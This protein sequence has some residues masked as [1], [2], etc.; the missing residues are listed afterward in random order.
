MTL[1]L[2]DL[3]EAVRS[4]LAAPAWL[5][6][7]MIPETGLSLLVGAPKSGKSL[8]AMALALAIGNGEPHHYL[9]RRITRRPVLLV[10][11]EGSEASLVDRTRRLAIERGLPFGPGEIFVAHRPRGFTLPHHLEA[12]RS[13]AD[14]VNAG[15]VIID[16]LAAVLGGVDENSAAG[17]APVLSALVDLGRDRAV[18]VIHH[19][20]K[21]SAEKNAAGRDPFVS[22][23]GS[24]AIFAAA[25]SAAVLETTDDGLHARL[26]IRPRDA[27]RSILDL[28]R[29]DDGL[30]W[31]SATAPGVA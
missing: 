11:M 28:E 13:A 23:R 9:G 3:A 7:E 1:A 22:I 10:E 12:L 15:L 14:E 29:R 16:P 30:L 31:R 6:E 19:A 27:R 21:P 18:L 25:D 26:V 20:G 4:P 8:L 2:R 24:S 5:V 17:I